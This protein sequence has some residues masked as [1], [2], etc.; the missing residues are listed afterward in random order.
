MPQLVRL[1]IANVAAGFAV[2]AAFV[3]AL[4]MLDVGGI[5][6]LVRGSDMGVVAALM[7]W[8]FN[9]VIFAGVQFGLAVMNLAEDG[10]PRGGL[11]E[12]ALVPIPVEVKTSRRGAHRR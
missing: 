8:V 6:H 7:L 5:G 3:F 9:G 2:S 10:G 1:Y 11:R 12:P 4:V